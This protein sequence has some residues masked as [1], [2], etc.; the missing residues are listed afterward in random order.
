MVLVTYPLVRFPLKSMQAIRAHILS[1]QADQ[2]TLQ[3]QV[4]GGSLQEVA[5]RADP[6]NP[7]A[8]DEYSDADAATVAPFS[9]D[10]RAWRERF[11][12]HS[13]QPSRSRRG[14]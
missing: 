14:D 13:G 3:V 8:P 6:P 7:D 9:S 11:F 10:P 4:R 1:A 12:P 5:M 2:L